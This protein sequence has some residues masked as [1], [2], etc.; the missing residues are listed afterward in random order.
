MG[1]PTYI[2]AGGGTGGHMY[3]GLAVADQISRNNPD[4][5]VAFACS[6][7][8]IDLEILSSTDYISIPQPTLPFRRNPFKMPSFLLAWYKS[9]RLARR[10]LDDLKP[11]S[12]LG[13][14]GFAAGAVVREAARK[15]IPVAIMNPDIIPG[16][17]NRYLAGR[18]DAIFTQFESTAG[19]F[20]PELRGKVR[21]TGCPTR[22]GLLE[23]DREEACRHFDLDPDCKT[24]IVF[25][26]SILAESITDSLCMLAD[27][28]D[29]FAEEWQ[30]LAIVGEKKL[31]FA[32]Q[33]FNNRSISATVLKYCYRMDLAYA[34]ADL[35]LTR[36]GAVTVAELTATATPA[37]I[38]PYPYHS[39]RQQYQNIAGLVKNGCARMV[40]DRCVPSINVEFLNE[41]LV[42]LMRDRA[43]LEG[44]KAAASKN[45]VSNA[46]EI[47]AGWMTG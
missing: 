17:A 8:P 38:M 32:R 37:V 9:L 7:R 30:I 34:V 46:A 40:E 35:A 25:G 18:V 21:K 16:R 42:P 41:T 13:L 2:I 29:E 36:G 14:G 15:S 11:V 5:V 43:A 4:A 26:G 6:N 3:P 24:L 28:M 19:E 31:D 47:I 27:D 10:V 45:A 22:P 1:N 33:V 20:P 12:V 44:M 39:D 23:G